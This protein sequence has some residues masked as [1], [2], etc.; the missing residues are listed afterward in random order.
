MVGAILTQN[1]SW[2]NVERAIRQLKQARALSARR[3]VGLK[4]STLNRLIRSSGY[5]R[6]KTVALQTFS[7]WYLA[8][9]GGSVR[10]M[11]RTD[12]QVLRRALLDVKG[13]GEE[14]ADSILL[15][16]GGQPVAVVD[17][18]TRRIFRRHR[19][20]KGDESYARLQR[21]VVDHLR[22]DARLYNEAHALLVAVGKR[23]CHTRHPDCACCP[24]GKFPHHLED[25]N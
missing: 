15:Y 13:I 17:A 19:L 23:Y 12:P 4:T 25:R 18:Y 21:Y 8:R 7:R 20:A 2:D 14:T 11:F 3:I 22:G 10:R 9:Y 5:F 1:T 6:Q 24:L 16:A